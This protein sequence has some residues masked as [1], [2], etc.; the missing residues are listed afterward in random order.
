MGP[1][2]RKATKNVL[3]L[4]LQPYT[5]TFNSRGYCL[6]CN[7]KCVFIYS[8]KMMNSFRQLISRWELSNNFKETLLERENYF[9]CYCGANNRMR[10][11]AETVL[12][13][14]NI[15]S[16]KELIKKLREN[17]DYCIYE[18][19]AYNVFRDKKLKK[20]NNYVV[21]EY[22]DNKSLGSHVRGIRNENL[23]ALTFPDSKF[24][25]L[26]NSDVLEHISDLNSALS[27]IKRVLKP[28]GYHVFTIPV[29]YEM[30][31]TTERAKVVDGSVRHLLEPV[32]HGD[33]IRGEGILAFRDFG[34]DVLD[35]MSRDGLVC[36]EVK[37]FQKGIYITSVYYAQKQE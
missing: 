14:L 19:A 35:Y 6:S 13:L 8:K 7:S 36:K 21:S 24:D 27:E 5:W 16:T 26:I 32:M 22:F 15:S 37:Y 4:I 30:E 10:F 3:K 9:C 20:L 25:I 11:H 34:R 12:K 23:E 33:P 29:D 1:N 28:G 17:P 31:K 18:T 2:I